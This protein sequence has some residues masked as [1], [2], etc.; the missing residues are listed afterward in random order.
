MIKDV[1]QGKDGVINTYGFS[2]VG[3]KFLVLISESK[4]HSGD[5]QEKPFIWFSKLKKGTPALFIGKVAFVFENK[6]S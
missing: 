2:L 5:E 3:C 1:H 4:W 6:G